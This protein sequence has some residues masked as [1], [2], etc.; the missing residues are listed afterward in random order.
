MKIKESELDKLKVTK[1]SLDK[2]FK[3]VK[4]LATNILRDSTHNIDFS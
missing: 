3:K 4:D 2:M 1:L